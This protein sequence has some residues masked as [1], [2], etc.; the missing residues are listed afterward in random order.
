MTRFSFAHITDQL[1]AAVSALFH[2]FRLHVGDPIEVLHHINW[3]ASWD[4][5]DD[6]VA[7][8]RTNR[9]ADMPGL[10]E[11]ACPNGH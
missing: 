11:R 2:G 4:V 5:V 6:S 8:Q 1:S 10:I 7:P 9:P 3:S